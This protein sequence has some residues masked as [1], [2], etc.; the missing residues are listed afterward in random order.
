MCEPQPPFD[1]LLRRA[2]E[3]PS[4]TAISFVFE[5]RQ[6]RQRERDAWLKVVGRTF[7]CNAS[8]P[9]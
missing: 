3:N 8:K 9:T 7:A 6:R 5:E 4:V 1:A 2:A